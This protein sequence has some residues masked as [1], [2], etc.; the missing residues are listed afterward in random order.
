MKIVARIAVIAVVV[1]FAS[2][3]QAHE[4]RIKLKD[5]PEPVRAAVLEQSKGGKIHALTREVEGGKTTYE[6]ELKFGARGK[7]IV[8]DQTG[9]VIEIEEQVDFSALPAAVQAALKAGAGKGTLGR[10][11]SITKNGVLTTYEAQVT[12]GG[13]KSEIKV[14]PDGSALK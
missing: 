5:L 10:V 1:A 2:V 11:E 12:A 3:A 6:A 14:A 13:K 9:T 7:D 4:K 8:M